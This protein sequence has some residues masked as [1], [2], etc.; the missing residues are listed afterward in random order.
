MLRDNQREYLTNKY[1]ND[2][3]FNKL[4]QSL[5]ML[6]EGK[7]LNRSDMIDAFECADMLLHDKMMEDLEKLNK[8]EL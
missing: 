7:I 4:V 5:V 1:Q 2:P 8:E 3:M 6:I